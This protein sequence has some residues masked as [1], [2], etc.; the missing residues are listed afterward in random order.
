MMSIS[1][2]GGA[3]PPVLFVHGFPLDHRMWRGQEPLAEALRLITFDLPGF[4]EAPPLVGEPGIAR[5]A[6]AVCEALDRAQQKRATLCGLSMGGYIL[7]EVWRRHP[8]RFERLVLC[9]TRA[10]ADTAEGRQ[11][12]QLGIRQIREGLRVEMLEAY[13]P[14]L[15]APASFAR[16][17]IVEQLRAM[18]SRASDAGIVAA[19]QTM[20]DRPDS[21][22]TL[23]T[24]RVPTLIIVGTEDHLT[25]PSAARA[26]ATAI[27]GARLVEIS[28][29]GHLSPLEN[30]E[31]FNTAL[32]SF[33]APG[34]A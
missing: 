5:Y 25:P 7:F 8:E 26:M 12:R 30:P 6:D 10:E 3:H 24:I 33:V 17:E 11:A 16:P 31:A 28:S 22:P 21:A 34:L 20:H 9:D 27:P 1:D 4:G 18:N 15:L 14:K 19:L 29:A 13:V 2:S 32:R 23:P